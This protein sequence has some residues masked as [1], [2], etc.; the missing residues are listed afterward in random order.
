MNV[1]SGSNGNWLNHVIAVLVLIGTEM[2]NGY[3][4]FNWLYNLNYDNGSYSNFSAIILGSAGAVLSL[5]L[6]IL[7]TLLVSS[8]RLGDRGLLVFFYALMCGSIMFMDVVA[9]GSSMSTKYTINDNRMQSSELDLKTIDNSIL[10]SK[11]NRD[12]ELSLVRNRDTNRKYPISIKDSIKIIETQHLAELNDLLVKKSTLIRGKGVNMSTANKHSGL[13]VAIATYLFPLM[14]AIAC[15]ASTIYLQVHVR[16][17]IRLATMSLENKRNQKWNSNGIENAETVMTGNPLN[18]F[19]ETVAH[20]VLRIDVKTK[21]QPVS[22]SQ[23]YDQEIVADTPPTEPE[24]KPSFDF[25]VEENKNFSMDN[26]HELHQKFIALTQTG[27]LPEKVKN[28][29]NETIKDLSI[30]PA[31]VE[32][33]GH[34]LDNEGL[35]DPRTFS[36]DEAYDLFMDAIYRKQFNIISAYYDANTPM[37]NT[38]MGNTPIATN[39]L[40]K[41]G[42]SKLT[43]KPASKSEEGLSGENSNRGISKMEEIKKAIE[44]IS[45]VNNGD[46][47]NCVM[48]GVGMVKRTDTHKFC[49][50]Q[51]KKRK[52]GGNCTNDYNN[53][54]RGGSS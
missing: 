17:D 25:E 9:G 21:H 38:P 22:V 51:N 46:R 36:S 26:L 28:R 31:I 15:M 11:S 41:Q 1:V 37:G 10:I 27:N 2:Y 44:K 39:S 40:D 48:C 13:V 43:S 30:I 6:V 35:L 5:S 3:H 19:V 20:K 33:H 53:I 16:S 32:K 4:V 12:I 49:S 54:I 14:L 8:I 24:K 50:H 47:G 29:I 23:N 52:D 7:T 18:G 45:A 42:E 34:K